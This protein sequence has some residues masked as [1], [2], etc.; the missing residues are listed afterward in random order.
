LTKTQTAP[1]PC[2]SGTVSSSSRSEKYRLRCR[3]RALRRGSGGRRA[4][5]CRRRFSFDPHQQVGDADID[6][7]LRQ[8]VLAWPRWC[9]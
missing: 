1:Q 4:G 8:Q 7:G 2:A 6:A 9:V 3:A 5:R